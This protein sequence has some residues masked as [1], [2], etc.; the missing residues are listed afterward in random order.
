MYSRLLFSV[1]ARV[2]DLMHLRNIMN[3]DVTDI[4]LW[5]AVVHIPILAEPKTML[6][7]HAERG[8]DKWIVA[9]TGGGRSVSVI[10]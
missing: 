1:W 7:E 4:D 10:Y 3:S 8:G 2:V 9:V 6:I 5:S